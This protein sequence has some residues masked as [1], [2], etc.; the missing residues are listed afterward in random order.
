MKTFKEFLL[1]VEEVEGMTKKKKSS[2]VFED[3]EHVLINH[4]KHI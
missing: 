1:E 4:G 3:E 2:T